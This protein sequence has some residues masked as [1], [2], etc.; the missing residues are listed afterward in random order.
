LRVSPAASCS[1][2]VAVRLGLPKRV[3]FDAVVAAKA[4]RRAN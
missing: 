3:V 4:G 1:A 2:T